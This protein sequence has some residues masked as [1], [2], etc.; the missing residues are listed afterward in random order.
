MRVKRAVALLE[1][2]TLR[3]DFKDRRYEFIDEYVECSDLRAVISKWFLEDLYVELMEVIRS[4]DYA[5]F[6]Q[7]SQL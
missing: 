7:S 3:P 5:R 1:T 4:I 6:S 2:R